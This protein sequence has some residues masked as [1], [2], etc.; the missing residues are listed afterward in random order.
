MASRAPEFVLAYDAN[1][2]P[3]SGFRAV[4]ELLDARRRIR[5]VSLRAAEESGLLDGIASASRYASFHLIR[6]ESSAPWEERL[7]SGSEALLPVVRLLSPWGRAISRIVQNTPGGSRA[8]S[9]LYSALSRSH[10]G[11]LLAPGGVSPAGC[12]AANR[13]LFG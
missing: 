3:C 6:S 13:G 9:F 1:C 4:V 5:F 2:G 10:K 7:W 8:V 12:P 11:C